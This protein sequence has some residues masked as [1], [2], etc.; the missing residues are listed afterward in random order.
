MPEVVEVCLIGQ[1]LNKKLKNTKIKQF[2]II[3]GRYS[4]HKLKGVNLLIN[5]KYI[6]KKVATKGKFLYMVLTSS[7]TKTLYLLN[8]FGLEGQWDL[9]KK[10]YSG[11][12][13]I[14]N[15]FNLY[16][17]DPR[18]FGT[19]EITDDV[20]VLNKKLNLLGDDLLQTTFTCQDLYD[21]IHNYI[22]D[23]KGSLRRSRETK[24]IVKILMD[25]NLS[26]GLGS[27]LGNYLVADVLYHAQI[28]PNTPINNIYT[29]ETKMNNLCNSI[30]FIVKFSYL[31]FNDGY[32]KKID[33]EILEWINKLRTEIKSND[34]HKFNF[35]PEI[36]IKKS[37]K[38]KFL[39]YKQKVDPK[40]N[41]VIGDKIIKGRT[42][43]FS[44]KIQK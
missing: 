9:I 17:T 20:Q 31:S 15:N 6:I 19:I 37:D 10:K 21:R 33:E 4:R 14:F 35:H 2:N 12:E 32:F 3:G 23:N 41:I 11:I 22:Y 26:T 13:L 38:Y 1:Y 5:N 25:Q 28:N 36:K 16:F 40:G 42:T 18:N 24:E 44:P 8:T 7:N 43:Y 39:V 34:K 29:N 27:G 30:K